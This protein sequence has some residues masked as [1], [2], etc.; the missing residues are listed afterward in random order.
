MTEA[1]AALKQANRF[2]NRHSGKFLLAGLVGVAWYNWRAW[3]KDKAM[4]ARRG[5]PAP[6]PALEGWPEL[7]PVSVLVAAWNESDVIR[8]HLES[9]RSLRYPHKELVLCAGGSDGTFALA[10]CYAGP[11]VL[12]LE[13][14]PGEGK[15]RAL[16]RCFERASGEVVFLTDADCLLDDDA[17]ERTLY[18]VAAAGEQACTGGSRPGADQVRN[19]F[20]IAQA[21]SQLY[22]S[23]HGPDYAS[24]LLGRNCAL[25]R[26]LLEASGGLLAPA[27]AGTDY[28]LAKRITRAG[29][30]I[31][32]MQA[33]RVETA[34]PTTARAYR[35]QQR[36]WLRNVAIHGFYYRA[37]GEV[38]RSLLPSAV[39]TL[40]LTGPLAATLLGPAA[41]IAWLLALGHM[42]ASRLRYLRVWEVLNH[43]SLGWSIRL[44]LP[45]YAFLDWVVWSA[46]WLDH[47][48]GVSCWRW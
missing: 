10:M 43:H 47:P 28:V 13:Q 41:F 30:S 29:A 23:L 46:V 42:L 32:Q 44:R 33:S 2:A 24:G 48:L 45:A 7:P 9:F 22:S 38:L 26:D 6:L 15:Q 5:R 19:P 20:V 40:M 25:R 31:R 35:R 14:L 27:P 1:V 12:V 8:R 36:R 18:P 17:F 21:A 37:Y 4:L 39:G 11:R 34:F 16:S 3:Q